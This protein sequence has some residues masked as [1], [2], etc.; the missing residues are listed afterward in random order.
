MGLQLNLIPQRGWTLGDFTE[1][2]AFDPDTATLEE[3]K[4]VLATLIDKLGASLLFPGV[5]EIVV[6]TYSFKRADGTSVFK[7]PGGTDNYLRA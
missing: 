5:G 2:K 4:Q 3:T 1:T 7:R 6:I